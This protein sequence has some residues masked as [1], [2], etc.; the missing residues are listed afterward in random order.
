M[1]VHVYLHSR[2]KRAK[3]Q[4]LLDSGATENFMAMDYAKHL[5][6]PIKELKEPQMLYNM[7]S[8]INKAGII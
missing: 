7:D 2:S 6:L 5:H 3:T 4:A 8:S 1:N